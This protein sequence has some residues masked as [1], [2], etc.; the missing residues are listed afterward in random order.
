[1]AFNWRVAIAGFVAGV[2][3]CTAA[4]CRAQGYTITT[5][6]GGESPAA[7]IGDGGPATSASLL[8]GPL[9]VDG[10]DNAIRKVTIKLTARLFR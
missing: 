2:S 10:A 9:A 7:R 4:L 1:M 8:P 6:A 3:L 5:V